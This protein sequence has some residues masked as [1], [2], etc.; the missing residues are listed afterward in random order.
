MRWVGRVLMVFVFVMVA[1]GG[2]VALAQAGGWKGSWQDSTGVVVVRPVLS[3][4]RGEVVVFEE[5]G[6]EVRAYDILGN[7]VWR[8]RL[9]AAGRVELPSHLTGGIYWVAF[10]DSVGNQVSLLRVVPVRILR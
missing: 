8:G 6:I 3:E 2:E 4:Q 10:F 9:S 7:E 1:A 5:R